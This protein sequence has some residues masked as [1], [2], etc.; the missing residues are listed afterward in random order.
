M[1]LRDDSDESSGSG[2]CFV[3][4]PRGE[5]MEVYMNVPTNPW[6]RLTYFHLLLPRLAGMVVQ[7]NTGRIPLM[8]PVLFRSLFLVYT[9]NYTALP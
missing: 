1:K 3:I 4:L 6:R 5:G 8:L 2:S 9:V 7:E